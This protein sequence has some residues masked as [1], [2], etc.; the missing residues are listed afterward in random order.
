MDC[1]HQ[2]SHCLNA[3]IIS[4]PYDCTFKFHILL[5]GDCWIQVFLRGV[6]KKIFLKIG[7]LEFQIAPPWKRYPSLLFLS[8]IPDFVFSQNLAEKLGIPKRMPTSIIS[9]EEMCVLTFQTK[10]TLMPWKKLSYLYEHDRYLLDVLRKL[11]EMAKEM[12]NAILDS[13]YPDNNGWISTG[14]LKQVTAVSRFANEKD[15]CILLVHRWPLMQVLKEEKRNFVD[16]SKRP[17]KW[18]ITPRIRSIW[19]ISMRRP[20]YFRSYLKLQELKK[21]LLYGHTNRMNGG[22][23]KPNQ[24]LWKIDLARIP[25]IDEVIMAF[26][27]IEKGMDQF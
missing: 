22:L 13:Y 2:G 17:I 19:C 8:F 1:F 23:I 18:G 25:V 4:K 14:D 26:Q 16:R 11:G 24:S 3:E 12:P 5:T 7:L 21:S 15:T 20:E 6:K 9:M 10:R 27:R